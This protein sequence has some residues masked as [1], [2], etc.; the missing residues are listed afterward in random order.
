MDH[1]RLLLK[2]K[3]KFTIYN[4]FIPSGL[5]IPAVVLPV[6]NVKSAFI[7]TFVTAQIPLSFIQFVSTYILLNDIAK[8]N[9]MIQM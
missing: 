5:R 3:R 2:M 1:G 7:N 4:I 9:Q 8:V 6:K